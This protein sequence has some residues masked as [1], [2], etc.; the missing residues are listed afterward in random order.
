MEEK[1]G[2]RIVDFLRK[3]VEYFKM[4]IPPL[5]Y[6]FLSPGFINFGSDQDRKK[7]MIQEL[8]VNEAFGKLTISMIRAESE[9]SNTCLPPFPRR[10]VLNNWTAIELPVVFKFSNE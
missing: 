7:S 2:K 4:E 6:L 8:D 5:S 3:V 1:R 9:A 10:Q